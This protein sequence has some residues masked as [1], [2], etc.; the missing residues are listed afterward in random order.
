MK[1]EL[2]AFAVAVACLG[3]SARANAFC[4]ATVEIGGPLDA[5]GCPMGAPLYWPGRCLGYSI[6]SSASTQIDY[7][8][9]SALIGKAFSTWTEPLCAGGKA[10]PSIDAIDLGP[11]DVTQVGYN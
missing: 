10:T 6:S 7:A 8:T 2:S 9:A 1:V 4:R 5:N 11:T 3:F